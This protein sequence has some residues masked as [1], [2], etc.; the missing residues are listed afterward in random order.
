[1]LKANSLSIFLAIS[2]AIV[3]FASATPCRAQ[4]ST[5]DDRF[6]ISGTDFSVSAMC[7]F[8]DGTG[9]ALF[10]S[11]SISMVGTTTVRGTAKWDGSHWT[12]AG[13]GSVRGFAVFD[14]GTGPALYGAGSFAHG[15]SGTFF[16]IAKWNG[17]DWVPLGGAVTAVNQP[18]ANVL[19][20]F[21][22]GSGPAL[23]VGGSFDHVGG[24]PA[25]SLAR[26]NGSSW[27]DVGGGVS[28]GSDTSVYAL[29]VHDDGSGSAL[30]VG[31]EFDHAGAVLASRIARWNG[32]AWSALST[33]VQFGSVYALSTFDDGT[34]SA[35]YIGGDFFSAGGV[36]ARGIARWN[37][38]SWSA[39]GNVSTPITVFALGAFDDGS[40]DAL[41]A[42]GK[43]QSIGGVAANSLARW[44][45]SSWSAP[46]GGLGEGL[47]QSYQ[48]EVDALVPFHPASGP[49]LC[50]G[51]LFSTAGNAPA[52]NLA[53]WNGSLWS[54]LTDD[55]LGLTGNTFAFTTFDDGTGLALY[56]AGGMASA[57][58][59]LANNIAKW[60][61]SSWSAL[62]S[63]LNGGVRALAVFDD[64]AGSALFAGGTF[65][66]AGGSSADHIAK[67]NGATW[68]A[69]GTG[70]ANQP[71]PTAFV[72]ALAAFD[73]G[74]GPALYAGGTFD[75]AGSVSVNG[76]AKWNGSSWSAVGSA[77]SGNVTVFALAVFDDGSGAALY[78]AGSFTSLGGV[79]AMN[80]AKWNGSSWS[81][82]GSG[83][84]GSVKAL[85]AFGGGT[86][87]KLY[88]G[89]SFTLAGGSPADLAASWNGSS[90]SALDN[91]VPSVGGFGIGAFAQFDD[92]SGAALIAG[93]D[94]ASL[95]GVAVHNIAKWNGVSWSPLGTGLTSPNAS[96]DALAVFEDGT[97]GA[98]D[99]YVGGQ[100]VQAG[101][102]PSMG[103]AEWHGCSPGVAF[104]AGDGTGATPC[105]C[106]NSG[107]SGRGC[108]NS[109]AT[110]GAHLGAGGHT[111]PDAVV[112]S[113]T[114]ELANA[115]SI[116]LQG[117]AVV[118]PVAFGDGVRCTGG[119]LKR[120]YVKNA[121]H[122]AVS[123]PESGDPSITARSAMLGDPIVH[124]T[125]RYYQTYYRDPNLAFCPPP[126]GNSWN[127]T[128]AVSIT[129]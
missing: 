81:A 114:H 109:A 122:G 15:A 62:G 96:A 86:G 18:F 13:A 87:A 21:D 57:G 49:M 17:T 69:L 3:S 44:K 117:D 42:G 54:P 35:L 32:S 50:V 115:L 38:S 29:S 129:W 39:V 75:I 53:G 36:T 80:I 30:Y 106:G 55:G 12:A 46:S 33:G 112:L 77:S 99:L 5:W 47:T 78:A 113:A 97:D 52:S 51:G 14:D 56:A 121:I 40:G 76:I 79:S 22:D 10:A 70:I 58:S 61:G 110:G 94:F 74:T 111:T 63:G 119:S 102:S 60:N 45:G 103:I 23:Y 125:T 31:G 34:G 100:F 127:V 41:W 89:G 64:G 107:H 1:M 83:T 27:V 95:G 68:S 118:S 92:G 59:A 85:L 88:A 72:Y 105:P 16:G 84:N 6:Y 67:W 120:L 93:G 7:S 24:V 66:S 82:L 48:V 37:G 104:C 123:A 11:G 9:P 98:P 126:Q 8:D 25:H 65:T 28:G 19:A 108:E 26:W 91:A 124:G 4:C 90:W 128:N 71:D 20:V 116:F 73:D 101:G 43:F 2:S